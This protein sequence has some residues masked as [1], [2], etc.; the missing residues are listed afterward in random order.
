MYI[1]ITEY[2]SIGPF[3]GEFECHEASIMEFETFNPKGIDESIINVI[4]SNDLVN[5]LYV[6]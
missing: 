6:D 5:F 1:M 3:D 4:W 2:T